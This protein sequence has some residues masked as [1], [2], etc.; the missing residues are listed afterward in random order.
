MYKYYWQW[1]LSVVLNPP[2]THTFLLYSAY[3]IIVNYY[4]N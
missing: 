1:Q 4:K 2:L 3:S